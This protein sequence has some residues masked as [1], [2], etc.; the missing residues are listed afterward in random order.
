MDCQKIHGCKENLWKGP[1]PRWGPWGGGGDKSKARE[2]K[3]KMHYP[4]GSCWWGVLFFPCLGSPRSPV[5][6]GTQVRKNIFHTTFSAEI[7]QKGG[8]QLWLQAPVSLKIKTLDNEKKK[9]TIN[10]RDSRQ[11]GKIL[12]RPL[13]TRRK[14]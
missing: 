13:K 11:A 4:W 12:R 9:K 7:V 8:I 1:Q 5:K 6:G 14:L 3:K 2:S 10:E